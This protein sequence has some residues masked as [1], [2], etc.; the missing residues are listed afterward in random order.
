V[1]ARLVVFALIAASSP[2]IAAALAPSAFGFLF[3]GLLAAYL[4]RCH[5]VTGV[6]RLTGLT[7]LCGVGFNF[8]MFAAM[9]FQ[10]APEMFPMLATRSSV[11]G[12][13]AIFLTGTLGAAI[14]SNV[15]LVMLPLSWRAA[16]LNAAIGLSAGAGGLLG[17]IGFVL[18]GPSGTFLPLLCTW[19]GGM[20]LVLTALAEMH[21][22]RHVP[23][24]PSSDGAADPLP[25]V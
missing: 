9:V 1:A 7:V 4:W 2:I 11:P 25:L 10:L 21:A 13:T 20:V 5:G 23:A 12:P 22:R 17:L 24:L 19:Q 8:S 15:F 6:G 16:R 18:D 3:G 14:I